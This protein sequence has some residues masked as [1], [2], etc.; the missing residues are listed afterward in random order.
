MNNNT[1]MVCNFD[2]LIYAH[3]GE[4]LNKDGQGR[5]AG[6][7]VD[8]SSKPTITRKV[9][10]QKTDS[11]KICPLIFRMCAMALSAHAHIYTQYIK[12]KKKI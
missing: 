5:I 3:T 10:N 1:F 2:S 9:E 4:G 6:A 8:L 7:L 12:K 11:T